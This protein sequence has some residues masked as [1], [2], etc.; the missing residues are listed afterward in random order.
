MTQKKR[1]PKPKDLKDKRLRMTAHFFPL[2]AKQSETIMLI[3]KLKKR[4]KK[5]A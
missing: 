4:V 1:G 2:P 3:E 5:L